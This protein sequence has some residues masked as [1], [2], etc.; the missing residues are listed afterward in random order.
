MSSGSATR[1]TSAW[2]QGDQLGERPPVGEAGLGLPVA[3]LVVA[4]A[5]RARQT[6]QA[7]HERHG[8]PVT[9]RPAGDAPPTSA[10]VPASSWPGT[11]G[12]VMP[13]SW[14]GPAVPVAAAQPG[15]LDPHHHTVRRRRRVGHLADRPEPPN[16]LKTTARTAILPGE[17]QGPPR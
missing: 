16:S 17:E 12:S 2:S 6:P 5:G 13:R 10:T 11:C 9:D 1:L 3:D 14:P 15:R 7:Q 4:G 8:H